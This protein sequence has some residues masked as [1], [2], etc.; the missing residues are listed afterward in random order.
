MKLLFKTANPETLKSAIIRK[1]E[2]AEL[3]TW[4]I[5][6]SGEVKYLKHTQQWGDKGVILLTTDTEKGALVVK[7]LKFPSVTEEL[8]DFEGYYYGRFCEIIFV[9]FPGRFTSI[10]RIGV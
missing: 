5:L 4:S 10:E 7:V 9:N 2:D 6:E 1:I 8:K 3:K